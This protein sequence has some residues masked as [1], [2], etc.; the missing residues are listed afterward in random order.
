MPVI[1]LSQLILDY[2]SAAASGITRLNIAGENPNRYF[3]RFEFKVQ[4]QCLSK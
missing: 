3:G 1:S 4:T 2:D